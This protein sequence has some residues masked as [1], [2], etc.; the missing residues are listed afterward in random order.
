V[1]TPTGVGTS[2]EENK[3][4]IEV[5]GKPYLVKTLR[6][7]FALVHEWAIFLESLRALREQSGCVR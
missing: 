2:V 4:R 5:D 3:Q 7:D 6:A 1:L